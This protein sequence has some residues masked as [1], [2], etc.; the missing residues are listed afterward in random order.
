M[1]QYCVQDVLLMPGSRRVYRQKLCDAWWDKIQAETEARVRYSQSS[2]FNGTGRHLA[3]APAGCSQWEPA[4]A[5]QFRGS[6]WTSQ[7]L[8]QART[9]GVPHQDPSMQREAS[10]VSAGPTSLAG[11]MR[12]FD[13]FS[14]DQKKQPD[15]TGRVSSSVSDRGLGGGRVFVDTDQEF[16]HD[17]SDEEPG[18]DLTACDLECGYRG[19]CPY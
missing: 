3:V 13:P 7:K 12:H 17:H 8:Q 15:D 19:R 10:M 9:D 16:E 1:E 14:V 11:L 4:V 5:Q 18:R 6:S 2:T